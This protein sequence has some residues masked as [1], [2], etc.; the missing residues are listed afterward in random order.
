MKK[1]FIYARK[2]SDS[3]DRQILSIESQ[4]QELTKIATNLKI[5]VVSILYESHS[6]KKKHTRKVFNQMLEEIRAGKANALL[7]WHT[8]RLS[9]N[10][11]DASDIIEL[12]DDE[13]LIEVRVPS[14]AYG[15]NPM[16]KFMLGFF[17]G[18]AKYEN[19]TKSL[20]VERGMKTKAEIGWYPSEAPTGYL[21][22][23]ERNKGLRIIVKDPKRFGLMKK[24]WMLLIK[25]GK[26]VPEILKIA[27]NEWGF[28]TKRNVPLSRSGL[29]KIFSNSFYCGYFYNQGVRYEGKHEAMITESEF[30]LAQT[31]LGRR[32]RT[33]KQ[34]HEFVYGNGLLKCG[35]CGYSISGTRKTKYYKSTRR[36]EEYIYYRCSRK[37]PIITC[38][39]IPVTENEINTQ[40]KELLESFEIPLEFK[41]WAKKYLNEINKKEHNDRISIVKSLQYSYNTTQKKIDNLLELKLQDLITEDEYR[42]KKL[43]L[44]KLRNKYKERLDDAE[45]RANN[46]MK[47]AEDILEIASEARELFFEGTVEEKKKILQALGSNFILKNGKIS[48]QLAKPFEIFQKANNR[49]VFRFEPGNN[50]IVAAQMGQCKKENLSWLPDEDSNLEP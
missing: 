15:N 40:I 12:M 37:N 39:D 28:T 33:R 36:N 5:H 48:I 30:D 11:G 4:I 47:Q 23:P 42:A 20:N 46:W 41:E 38:D 24:M 13:K 35:I 22:T 1:Y 34:K 9:R 29:Y 21:N 45:G 31:I 32:D 25:D 3:E 2:S 27:N 16:D 10:S 14:Q 49:G 17:W 6:A 43:D 8:D 50:T 26:T 18:Q 19:D 7:V 44:M